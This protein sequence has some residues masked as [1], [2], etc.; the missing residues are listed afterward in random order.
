MINGIV[1]VAA[2]IAFLIV[3]FWAIWPANESRFNEA[4]QLP[5]VDDIGPQTQQPKRHAKHKGGA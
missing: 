1:T 3:V 4:A 5:L 2:F